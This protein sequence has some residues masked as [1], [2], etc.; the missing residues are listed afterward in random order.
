MTSVQIASHSVQRG[1]VLARL[2]ACSRVRTSRWRIPH[3]DAVLA[4][5]R[6]SKPACPHHK[7]RALV[8]EQQLTLLVPR[9]DLDKQHHASP[10]VQHVLHLVRV[11][12][13]PRCWHW[14][15]N[16]DILLAME[17]LGCQSLKLPRGHVVIQSTYLCIF[18]ICA[19]QW[20]PCM[21]SLRNSVCQ[22]FWTREVVCTW[23]R[24]I[25]R[26]GTPPVTKPSVPLIAGITPK[27]GRGPNWGWSS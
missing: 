17:H 11:G 26:P 5:S 12:E 8:D 21:R 18:D 23:V 10:L 7:Y 4:A 13:G 2:V 6:S 20:P 27:V 3:F 19:L 16:L 14:L 15:H 22:R 24:S 9:L 25:S 1:L